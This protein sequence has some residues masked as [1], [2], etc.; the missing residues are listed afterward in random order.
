LTSAG[1]E[2]PSEYLL[3]SIVTPFGLVMFF[4]VPS[5]I[6][7]P[8]VYDTKT[9]LVERIPFFALSLV[10]IMVAV[11]LFFKAGSP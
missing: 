6:V 4:S 11:S 1:T 7:I 2:I 9:S 5:W 3:Y 10:G 8:L